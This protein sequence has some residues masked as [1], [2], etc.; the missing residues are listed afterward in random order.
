MANTNPNLPGINIITMD[1]VTKLVLEFA[2]M[3]GY[4]NAALTVAGFFSPGAF[5]I[6]ENTGIQYRNNGTTSAPAF[7]TSGMD[8]VISGG[9]IATT[10]NTDFYTMAPK[11]GKLTRVD[12]S[13]LAGLATN[14]TNY[15]TFTIT[16]LGQAGAGT[17]AMLASSPAGTNT[18]KATG[19]AAIAANTKRQLTLTAVAADLVVAAGDRLL[20]RAAATGTLANTVTAPVFK[21]SYQ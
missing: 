10:G 16:N 7:I 2:I 13:A 17:A 21:L 11:A 6:D 12:L 5:G 20:I 4:S 1:P 3:P 14:D 18:T 9:T 15:L 19:G 8:V